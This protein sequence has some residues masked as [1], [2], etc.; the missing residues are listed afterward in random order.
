VHY[1]SAEE[2]QAA[3]TE[4]DGNVCCQL[5]AVARKMLMDLFFLIQ[6]F[7]WNGLAAMNNL[8]VFGMWLNCYTFFWQL[9]RWA[10]DLLA[11]LQ[12]ILE[13]FGQIVF[14]RLH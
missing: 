9:L 6:F 1:S 5:F 3:I 10:C 13:I 11:Y 4:M 12:F 14:F 8:N 2:A 7:L